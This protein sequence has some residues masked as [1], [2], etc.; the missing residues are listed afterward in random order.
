MF[1]SC[2]SDDFPAACSSRKEGKDEPLF[3]S[4]LL[5]HA[6]PV[7]HSPWIYSIEKEMKTNKEE[8]VRDDP[9]VVSLSPFP[10]YTHVTE[11]VTSVL[12]RHVWV[13]GSFRFL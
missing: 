10:H 6:S 7:Y 2:I 8:R 9:G 11:V 1:S 12:S 3:I 13:E 5:L 4:S